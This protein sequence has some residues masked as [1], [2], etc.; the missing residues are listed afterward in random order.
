MD[1][2][3]LISVKL[4]PIFPTVKPEWSSNKDRTGLE[5]FVEIINLITY[6]GRGG[7]L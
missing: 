2:G 3:S 7:Q 4:V 6:E 1:N 5:T